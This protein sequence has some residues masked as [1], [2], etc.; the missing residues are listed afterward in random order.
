VATEVTWAVG[1]A[2]YRSEE[3]AARAAP[4]YNPPVPQRIRIAGGGLSGLA[5]AVLLA[6]QGAAVEVYDRHRGGGGRF[7]GGWQVLENGSRELDALAEL[8]AIGLEPNFPALPA[9]RALF[10]DG[11]GR[12][13]E[14][15]SAA[16]Y[17]YF[18]RRGGAEGSLDSWLRVLALDAGVVLREGV[19]APP[20]A[21]VI[22]SG[23]RQADGVARE[24]VFTSDLPDTV[25]VLFDPAV[26]PTGY[27]YLFCLGGHATFGVAQVRRVRRLGAA[28]EAAWRR[29]REVLGEFDVRNQ[30]EHGQFMNFYL[31]RHLRGDDGRWHVGENAG[32]QDFLFGLGNRLALR[33][34]GL[35][36]AGM[37]GRWDAAAFRSTL[38]RPMR[39]TVALRFV[40]ERMGRRA[41]GAF[42][43]RASRG[44]FRRFLI[45]LQ[46]PDAAKDAVARLVMAAWRERRG[47]RHTPLCSWC[48]KREP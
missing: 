4:G 36:A 41:F 12:R 46:R 39:T 38:L 44:D 45:R 32:V 24:L 31:P 3:A 7:T 2:G 23:P 47:C 10:L 22:A 27:A 21:G 18:V 15:A 1:N 16:P 43:N 37:T 25:A 29:F 40:Y 5:T 28:R 9:T 11:F 35:A 30:N 48:R 8:R 6:R 26:T 20:D 13:F 17:A 33:S 34:A 42:C 19:A 14:V